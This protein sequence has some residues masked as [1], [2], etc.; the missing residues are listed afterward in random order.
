M[1]RR[2]ITGAGGAHTH[3]SGA[4]K[5]RKRRKR[6]KE[7][8]RAPR[9]C[10]LFNPPSSLSSDLLCSLSSSNAKSEKEKG[11]ILQFY[12]IWWRERPFRPIV[13]FCVHGEHRCS[14]TWPKRVSH[15][16]TVPFQLMAS[17]STI[18]TRFS[19]ISMPTRLFIM[20]PWRTQLP[21]WS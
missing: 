21:S 5:I 20:I 10:P 11:S 1:Y 14:L 6:V 9:P 3:G 12:I 7:G 13:Q 19:A 8:K 2:G 4:R 16:A 17:N 18:L 15:L